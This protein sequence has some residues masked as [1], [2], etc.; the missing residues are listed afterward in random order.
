M[1]SE[2]Q[3]LLEHIQRMAAAIVATHPA[4]SGLCLVGG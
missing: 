1:P 2:R 4:G 3:S